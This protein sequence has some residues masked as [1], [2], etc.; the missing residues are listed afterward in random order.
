MNLEIYKFKLT[1]QNAITYD[2][3]WIKINDGA[4]MIRLITNQLGITNL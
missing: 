1:D 3:I 2:V 4:Y